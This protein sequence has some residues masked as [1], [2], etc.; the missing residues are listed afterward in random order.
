M[1]QPKPAPN[2][3]PWQHEHLKRYLETNGADGHLWQPQSRPGGQPVPTLILTTTGR[4][5]GERYLN[6]L[7][8]GRSNG[9]GYV[10]I[11]SKGGSPTHPA[12]YLNLA[13]NPDVEVQA[14]D[15]KFKARARTASGAERAALWKQMAAIFPRYE[16]YKQAAGREIPVVVLDPA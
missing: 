14:M 4:R 12:W 3:Q 2:M 13:A 1:N 7:I 8:Y 15:R 16:D 11:A 6:P 10:V 5:T 9:G